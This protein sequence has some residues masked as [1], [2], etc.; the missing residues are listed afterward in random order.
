MRV[1]LSYICLRQVIHCECCNFHLLKYNFVGT[2][3]P[4]F[5]AFLGQFQFL[6]TDITLTD[7][8]TQT[9]SNEE[10]MR[11]EH[12]KIICSTEIFSIFPVALCV[13]SLKYFRIILYILKSFKANRQWAAVFSSTFWHST[14]M[15][16]STTTKNL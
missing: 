11:L 9:E 8:Q 6:P 5:T 10:E 3:L 1:L 4:S 13:L 12:N 16:F 15:I 7:W 14:N 2:H